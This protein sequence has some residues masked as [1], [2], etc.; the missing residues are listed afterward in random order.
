MEMF[1]CLGFVEVVDVYVVRS[2][3]VDGECNSWG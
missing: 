1:F 2:V 3:V